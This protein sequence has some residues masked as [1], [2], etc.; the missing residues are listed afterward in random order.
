MKIKI[1]FEMKLKIVFFQELNPA[2]GG[3]WEDV[4]LEEWHDER[5]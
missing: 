5:M 2:V 4:S 3:T 1:F